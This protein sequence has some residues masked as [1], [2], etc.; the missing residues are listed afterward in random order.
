MFGYVCMAIFPVFYAGGYLTQL[1]ENYSIWQKAG[2]IRETELHRPCPKR[3]YLYV[4]AQ[5]FP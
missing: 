4:S 2:H 3:E 1:I 5:H